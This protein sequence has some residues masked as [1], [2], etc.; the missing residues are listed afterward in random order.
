VS[1]YIR[2]DFEGVILKGTPMLQA[3]P[4]KRDNWKSE[5]KAPYSTKI[6]E[7]IGRALVNDE[8][9]NYLKKFWHKKTYR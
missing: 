9:R 3:I 4:F 6:S 1:F 2:E 7:E 5:V 8:K